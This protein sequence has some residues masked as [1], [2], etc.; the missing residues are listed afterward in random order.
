MKTKIYITKTIWFI[1]ALNIP[2]TEFSLFENN[3]KM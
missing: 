2:P 1:F 3:N